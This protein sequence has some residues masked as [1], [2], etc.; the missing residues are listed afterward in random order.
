MNINDILGH[1]LDGKSVA[2][3]GVP[4]DDNSSFMKGPAKA[5][6]KIREAFNSDATN[7]CTESG[8]DL[9]KQSN[10]FDVGDLELKKGLNVL[11]YIEHIYQE[12]LDKQVRVLSLGGDHA[13]T[14]PI[15]QAYEKHYPELNIL[16][17]DAHPDLYDEFQGNRYSHACPFARVME[18]GLIKKLVQVG[19]RTMT[20]HQQE[21]ADRF[22]VTLIDMKSWP[23][24]LSKLRFTGPVYISLDLDVLDPA[25][26]PGVSHPEPGGLR[27]RDV[28]TIIQQ[29]KA[30]IVGADI[31]EYNPLR[32]IN[33]MTAMVAAKLLKELADK[34]LITDNF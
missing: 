26:A 27:T 31:V 22:N 16:H 32:D 6:S 4:Y 25:C 17:F 12:L 9:S 23:K 33:G 15:I 34:M 10:F 28:I 8:L 7:K 13:V 11:G 2:I 30:P 21:Q 1:K 18:E 24:G 3:V 20:P 29:I 19:I 5:P 14:L